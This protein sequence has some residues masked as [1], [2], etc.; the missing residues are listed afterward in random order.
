MRDETVH[1]PLTGIRLTDARTGGFVELGELPGVRAITLIRHRHCLLCQEHVIRVQEELTGTSI[2]LVTV[3]FS[4]LEALAALA[5]DLGLRGPMLADPDRV[6]Y[7]VLGLRRAPVWRVYSPATMAFYAEASR[8]GCT[9]HKPVEDTRQLGG[10]ALAVDGVITR[11]W[12]PAT[13]VDRVEPGEVADA[14][15]V[16]VS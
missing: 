12:L 9:L 13:P 5:E 16:L 8:R 14:A 11:C 3:G 15:R 4:P 2:P 6:L 10:D 7:G 1:L